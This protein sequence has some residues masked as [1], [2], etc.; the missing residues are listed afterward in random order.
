[1]SI[2]TP[3]DV[4]EQDDRPDAP[5]LQ[6]KPS[7]EASAAQFRDGAALNS[8]DRLVYSYELSSN[9]TLLII[10]ELDPSAPTSLPDE[11]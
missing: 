7:L 9:L 8:S 3:H 5:A 11:Q 10:T 1:M 4:N 2:H 6:R